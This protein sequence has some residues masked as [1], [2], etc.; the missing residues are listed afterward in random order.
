MS[1]SKSYLLISLAFFCCDFISQ[2]PALAVEQT[3][4]AQADQTPTTVLEQSKKTHEA[5]SKTSKPFPV[6][7]KSTERKM[8]DE[9]GKIHDFPTP[10]QADRP[11]Y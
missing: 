8:G 4:A 9:P 1:I 6:R 10:N 7:K 5:Q 11:G 3:R 2:E